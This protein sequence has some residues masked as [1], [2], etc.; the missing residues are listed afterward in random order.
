MA[1][2]GQVGEYVVNKLKMKG[3]RLAEIE[4]ILNQAK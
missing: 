4:E 1:D 2:R 3:E